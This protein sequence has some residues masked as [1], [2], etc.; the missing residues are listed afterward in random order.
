MTDAPAAARA[1]QPLASTRHTVRFLLIVA[2]I[3]AAGLLRTGAT[4]AAAASPP[5][6]R[7]PLYLSLVL[8][9][10]GLVWYVAI[11]VRH[12]GHS[13]VGLLGARW[14]S[15][16]DGARDVALAVA[17]TVLLRGLSAALHWLAG[18]SHA[19]TAFVLPR[20]IAESL[21]WIVVSLAAGACEEAAFRG[22]LQPQLWALTGSLPVAV[23][24]QAL[25]FG[26][27]H[28]YQG[29]RAALV[30]ALYGLAFGLLAAWRRSIVPGI[31]AHWLVDVI[32]GLVQ[33]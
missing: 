27:A 23:V 31:L 24:G 3:A 1:P 12:Q 32:G 9:E 20:G 28:L 13:I 18:P 5:A 30:T 4:P 16:R 25:A 17:M 2:G 10:L 11:G 8:L 29:W 26:I 33:P 6:S 21:L 7:V 15:W 14:R 19:R 22:Y